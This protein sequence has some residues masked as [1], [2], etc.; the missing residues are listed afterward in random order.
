MNLIDLN[1]KESDFSTYLPF[2]KSS[3]A[4]FYTS[5]PN[6]IKQ[7]VHETANTYFEKPISFITASDY[8]EYKKT[9]N[10]TNFEELYF[11]RRRSLASLVMSE[12]ISHNNLYFDKIIDL[13]ICICEESGWQIPAHNNYFRDAETL[14]LPDVSN[15]VLDLFALET[16]ALLATTLYLLENKFIN[17]Y[18]YVKNRIKYELESRIINTY[19]NKDF[20]WMGKNNEPTLNWTV[21]CTQNLLITVFMSGYTKNLLPISNKAID[22][23]SAFLNDY[24]EDGC[25]DE[26]A[27]YFRHAGLCL[28]N[29]L[30]IINTVT[31]N[32]LDFVFKE[33]KVKNIANYIKNVHVHDKYF[34]NFSDCSAIAGYAGAR[35]YLFA[36]K[37]KDQNLIN[38]SLIQH[39]KNPDFD[40]PMETNLFYKMTSILTSKKMFEE[41]PTAEVI[42]N[43]IYYDGVGLL[44]ARDSHF[45]L[46][47]KTGSNNDNHNHNDTGSFTLYKNGIPIIID[48][49]VESY[50]AKTFSENRYEIWTMQSSYHNLS[51]FDG[52]MQKNG[53]EFSAEKIVTNFSAEKTSINMNLENAY[54][55]NAK[56]SSYTRCI[57]MNKNKNI[58]VNECVNGSFEDATLFL[59]FAE[60]PIVKDNKLFIRNVEISIDSFKNIS[61]EEIKITDSKL[62]NVWGEKI[63]RAKIKYNKD[64]NLVIV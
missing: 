64:I 14:P 17:E 20:W 8:L 18:A 61:I 24:H 55:D 5:L 37:I 50:S 13:I 4:S 34:L 6:N 16:S 63:Y 31:N 59:M 3:D 60:L 41:K 35:E 51:E 53:S 12:T 42:Y 33:V 7:K 2:P 46:G 56:L 54:P 29:S 38:F 15:P 23:I 10:R 32:K 43:D 9:G 48:I 11:E 19:L 26:G 27:E 45:T 40:L 39:S 44:V 21:W 1:L 57:T 30:N 49:G 22:S 36:K 47:V 58:I 52:V 25:C 62:F 28:F